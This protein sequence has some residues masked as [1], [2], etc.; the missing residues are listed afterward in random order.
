MSNAKHRLHR[1]LNLPT[2][3]RPE[4][5]PTT[6]EFVQAAVSLD[7][8]ASVEGSRR[9]FALRCAQELADYAQEAFCVYENEAHAFRTI[10]ASVEHPGL[11][12]AVIA[13]VE[14]RSL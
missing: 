13:R 5:W 8:L 11:G 2:F 7:A 6:Y 9:A 1:M 10:L 14:P 12:W 4:A 3:L